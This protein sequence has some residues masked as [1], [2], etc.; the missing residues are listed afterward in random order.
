MSI[1]PNNIQ[2]RQNNRNYKM[3][4]F[5]YHDKNMRR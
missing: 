4:I 2:Y 1:N 3:Y 5:V